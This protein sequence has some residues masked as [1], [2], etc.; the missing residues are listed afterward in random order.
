MK[1]SCYIIG[2]FI[3]LSCASC[4]KCIKCY[5]EYTWVQNGVNNYDTSFD[6]KKCGN[7]K[8]RAAFVDEWQQDADDWQVEFGGKPTIENLEVELMCFPD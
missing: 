1:I 4:K 5:Y 6:D 3:F 2:F 7:R 8:K